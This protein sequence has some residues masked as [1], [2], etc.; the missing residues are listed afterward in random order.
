MNSFLSCYIVNT[1][2][3]HGGKSQ[4]QNLRL[5][6]VVDDMNNS[7]VQLARSTSY[8]A[9]MLQRCCNEN[10]GTEVEL[11]R[12]YKDRHTR[13]SVLFNFLFCLEIAKRATFGF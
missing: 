6:A 11:L 1:G 8:V 12:N 5:T 10:V 7:T 3:F 13:I 9:S 4:K 2:D